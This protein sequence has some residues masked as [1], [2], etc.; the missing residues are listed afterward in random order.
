MKGRKVTLRLDTVG[1]RVM[2]NRNIEILKNNK[3]K[4]E[5]RSRQ[6]FNARKVISEV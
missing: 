5:H 2:F 1:C 6:G 4:N 3:K